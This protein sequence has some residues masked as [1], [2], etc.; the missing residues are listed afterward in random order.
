MLGN[1]FNKTIWG[2]FKDFQKR[3]HE[4]ERILESVVKKYEDSIYFMVDIDTC[5]IEAADPRTS[6]GMPM[7]Y[8]VEV[9]ILIAYVDHFLSTSI[10]PNA[11][12]FGTFKEKSLEVHSELAKLV[13][14]KKIRKEF[15]QFVVEQS[16]TKEMINEARAKFE[17][18]QERTSSS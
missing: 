11:T 7:G 18:K 13:I 8:E 2:Y 12:R 3:I 9:D 16:F 6:S 1:E 17:A 10:D 15:E 5:Q 14:A 4:R